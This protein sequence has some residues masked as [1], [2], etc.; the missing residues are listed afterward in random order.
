MA[1]VQRWIQV[2][3][4]SGDDRDDIKGG[5]GPPEPR[6]D[7]LEFLPEAQILFALAPKTNQA[8]SFAPGF[9]YLLWVLRHFLVSASALARNRYNVS[10]K[11]TRDAFVPAFSANK[12][13]AA[14]IAGRA[15]QT[16]KPIFHTRSGR[17]AR[18]PS[19]SRP[20]QT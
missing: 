7:Q 3:E 17:P 15:H 12:I 2:D 5:D 18:C 9:T 8:H 6:R 20:R 1:F 16:P 11:S 10:F 14:M 4:N 13:A 19:H